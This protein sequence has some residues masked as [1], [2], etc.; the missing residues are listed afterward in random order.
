MPRTTGNLAAG[1]RPPAAPTRRWRHLASS[2]P[3]L[4]LL[5][6]LSIASSRAQSQPADELRVRVQAD[7]GP[8]YQ[9]QA[10]DLAVLIRGENERPAIELPHLDHAEISMAGTSFQPVSASSIGGQNTSENTFITRLRVVARRAGVLEIPPVMA[11]LGARAGRGKPLRLAIEPV[12]V[13]GRPTAFL[14]GVGDFTVK[15]SASPA[16]V[17]VGQELTYRI[18]IAGPAAWG[19][20]RP[21]DLGR[22]DRVPLALRVQAL[23]VERVSDPPSV[24]FPYR[25]RPAKAGSAALP[26][27]VIAAFDPKSARYLT[28]VTQGLPIKASATAAFDPGTIRYTAPD[29]RGDFWWALP[30]SALVLWLFSMAALLLVIRRRRKLA[31]K[32]SLRAAQRLARKLTQ[33]LQRWPGPDG[34]ESGQELAR[35]I[36]DGLITY[37]GLSIGRP[38]GALTPAEARDLVHELTRSA[39]LADS[40]AE[41]VSRCDHK[42]FSDRQSDERSHALAAS[43]RE[44]FQAL[45]REAIIGPATSSEASEQPARASV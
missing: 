7:P 2:R 33:A 32:G 10:I 35:T 36:S 4:R 39:A 43:A 30:A 37:A 15:A 45:G 40:A 6:I 19:T 38:P 12:P 29:R 18:E 8:H 27:V 41:I 44:L 24:V 17:R 14:G 1:R 16:S 26:P 21:P 28:K 31:R 23:P 42:L 20:M 34:L 22:F 5:L 9:G 3:T 25:I 13:E 11:R